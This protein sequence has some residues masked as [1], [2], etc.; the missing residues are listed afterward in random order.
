M[1]F[2]WLPSGLSKENIIFIH[3]KISQFKK[4]S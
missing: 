4:G 2:N 1:D 3:K